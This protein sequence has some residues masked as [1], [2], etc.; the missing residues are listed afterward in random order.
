MIMGDK[1]KSLKRFLLKKTLG[2]DRAK[3]DEW[4]L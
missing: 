4:H 3:G 2:H 1:K